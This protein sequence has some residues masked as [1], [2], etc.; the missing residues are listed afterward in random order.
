MLKDTLLYY[1]KASIAVN[2]YSSYPYSFVS[3]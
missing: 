3:L 2:Y 1:Y